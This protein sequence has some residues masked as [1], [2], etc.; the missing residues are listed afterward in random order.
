M[1]ESLYAKYIKEREDFST[2]E[3]ERGFATYR[4]FGDEVYLRDIYVLPEHRQEGVASLLADE[5]GRI[6]KAAGCKYL[7]GTVFLGLPSTTASA[8]TLLAYGMKLHS[9]SSER[10]VFTMEL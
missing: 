1:S 10:L 6:G 7:T 9:A 3:E 2:L 5:V 4:V 8:K